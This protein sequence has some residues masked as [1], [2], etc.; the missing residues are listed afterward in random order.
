MQRTN[1]QSDKAYNQYDALTQS[2]HR[3]IRLQVAAFKIHFFVFEY[4]TCIY[5]ADLCYMSV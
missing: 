3:P 2:L 1:K 5:L 4:A